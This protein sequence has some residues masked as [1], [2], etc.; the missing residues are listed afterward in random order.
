MNNLK[1]LL[2]RNNIVIKK[3]TYKNNSIIIE[4]EK[5]KYIIKDKKNIKTKEL[6]TYLNNRN[7]N[8]YIPLEID[9]S[10]IEIYKYIEEKNISK[11]EKAIDLIYVM[12]MLH[13]KTTSYKEVILD[14]VKKIYEEINNRI[15]YLYKYYNNMQDNIESKTYYSPEEY[16]LIRNISYIYN[17]LDYSKLKIEKW[18]ELKKQETKERVVQLH[19]NLS[20]DHVIEGDKTY[21]I[22]WKKAKKDIVIYD[23]INF[24]KNEYLNLEMNSLFKIYQSKYKYTK[25]EE[26][27]FSSILSLPYKIEFKSDHYINTQITK[28][29]IKYI[30]KTKKFLLEEYEKSEEINQ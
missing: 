23:F 25:D 22:S 14:D 28:K 1:E 5:E 20:I 7:F 21:L 15:N 3:I 4:T 9:D 17:S 18:Y 8:N 24:Y 10:N 12:S 2:N 27:L 26:Q 29:L 13:V 16:L 30:I 6:Y 11:E 19:N